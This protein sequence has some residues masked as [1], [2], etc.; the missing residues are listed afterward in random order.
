MRGQTNMLLDLSAR[1]INM[2][3]ANKGKP[4]PEAWNQAKVEWEML[5]KK[6]SVSSDEIQHFTA[7]VEA[8][9]AALAA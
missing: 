3:E 5:S 7:L 6:R 1:L 2:G 4:L 9:E 8:A